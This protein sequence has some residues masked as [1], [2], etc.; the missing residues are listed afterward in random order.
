MNTITIDPALYRNMDKYAQE[1]NLSVRELAENA[2][3]QFLSQCK[4][5]VATKA[6]TKAE[7]KE[8]Y[9]IDPVL[10]AVEVDHPIVADGFSWDYKKE[11][12]EY[13]A[14]KYM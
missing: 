4:K 10:K 11:I 13:R 8:R 5:L 7:K 14:K 9:F 6:A 12:G 3:S 1:N 2:I